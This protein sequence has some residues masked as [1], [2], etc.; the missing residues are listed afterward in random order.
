MRKITN[1]KAYDAY[2]FE[3]ASLAFLGDFGAFWLNSAS[4]SAMRVARWY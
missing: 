3:V 2:L 1:Q 4:S